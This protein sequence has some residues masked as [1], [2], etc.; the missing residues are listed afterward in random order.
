M[1]SGINPYELM[2]F[3][4]PFETPYWITWMINTTANVIRTI[5]QG[6]TPTS[7][8]SIGKNRKRS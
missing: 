6:G 8:G 1:E 2:G 7:P 3:M 5:E 4:P